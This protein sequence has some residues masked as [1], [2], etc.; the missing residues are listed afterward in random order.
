MTM[1]T[2]LRRYASLGTIGY[3]SS[4][5]GLFHNH[6]N[7]EWNKDTLEAHFQGKII[8]DKDIFDGGIPLLVA[9]GVLEV[10]ANGTYLTTYGYRQPLHSIGHCRC[11][12]LESIL[13]S[14]S[15]DEEVYDIFSPEFCSYDFINNAIQVGKSAFGLRYANIRDVLL[16]LGFLVP[17]PNYPNSAYIINK[18]HKNLFDRYFTDG[19]RKHHLSPEQLKSI[20]AQQQIN[21]AL[22][23]KFVVEY[24]ARRIG[25]DDG[26]EWIANYDTAA[27][28]DIMSF[29]HKSSTCH[30]RF[31]EV[32]T[33]TG[34]SPQF[35]W[36]RNEMRVA[37]EKG[38]GYY[39]YLVS[40]DMIDTA[41]Y[42]PIIIQDPTIEVL[43]SS[44]WHKIVDKYHIVQ[45]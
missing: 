29:E 30:D 38:R 15:H 9:A 3:Y 37:E 8:D 28:F 27:G 25:R 14:L 5:L 40:L 11:K 36:S 35:F 20:Q 34:T 41:G 45:M 10:D 26:I 2:E 12:I 4:V 22:G 43:S 18:T 42:V 13:K 32:K 1:L 33:Y 31:I 23:E 16:N 24:E 39:L 6:P 21:G 17:H 7:V 19:L 44:H